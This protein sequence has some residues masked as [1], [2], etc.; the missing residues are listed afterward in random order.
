MTELVSPVIYLVKTVFHLVLAGVLSQLQRTT[1][2]TMNSIPT[3][4]TG[5]GGG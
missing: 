3:T 1:I 5:F 2:L 4:L